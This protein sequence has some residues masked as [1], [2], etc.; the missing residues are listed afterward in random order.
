MH[1]KISYYQQQI[2][3]FLAQKQDSIV[4]YNLS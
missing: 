4:H 1:Q 3:T 2:S